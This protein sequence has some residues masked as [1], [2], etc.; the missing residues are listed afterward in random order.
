MTDYF[1]ALKANGV[2]TLKN[3]TFDIGLFS[4][5]NWIGDRYV[6]SIVTISSPIAGA[7]MSLAINGADLLGKIISTR[8]NN[9]DLLGSALRVVVATGSLIGS[10]AVTPSLAGRVGI[11]ISREV[12]MRYTGTAALV[13]L[14]KNIIAPMVINKF[15]FSESDIN[16]K[17]LTVD[18]VTDSKKYSD[19]QILMMAEFTQAN[20]ALAIDINVFEAIQN[21]ATHIKR[22]PENID[23]ENLTVNAI[24]EMTKDQILAIDAYAMSDV[25]KKKISRMSPLAK[26][27]FCMRLE[28]IKFKPEE[29]DYNALTAQGVAEFSDDQILAIDAFLLS[30]TIVSIEKM[31]NSSVDIL[32]LISNR[33]AAIKD[34]NLKKNN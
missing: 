2:D 11:E 5:A 26:N 13:L 17:K 1:N 32:S 6:D 8:Y 3:F 34:Q 15:R 21:R 19:D 9:N 29:V 16:Y 25:G 18:E 30:N 22:K 7:T 31:H 4:A 12:M 27:A 23:Y 10:A 33:A 14:L 20:E 24:R 28:D